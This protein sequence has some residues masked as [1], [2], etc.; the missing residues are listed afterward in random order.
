MAYRWK[1]EG[2]LNEQQN[3]KL[4]ELLHANRLLRLSQLQKLALTLITKVMTFSAFV[5]ITI[6]NC[7]LCSP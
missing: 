6:A 2:K 3:K 7:S 4:L 1:T 5:S